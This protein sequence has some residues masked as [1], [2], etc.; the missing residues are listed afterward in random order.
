ME[1]RP[2]R[3][4]HHRHR[5]DRA[6]T[7]RR[8]S[9]PVRLDRVHVRGGDDL[10]G[11]VPARPHQAAL[12]AGR[13]VAAARARDRRRCPPTPHRVAEPRPG[14]PV[15]LHQ[16]AAHVRVA[17]PGRRVRV[18]GERRP[19]GAAA[20]LVLG[21]VGP[22]AG[23]VGLLRLPG[24]DPVLD[25]HLPRARAGAVHAVGGADHLVVAPAVPVE[26]VRLPPAGLLQGPQVGRHLAP[27]QV[28]PAPHQCLVQIGPDTSS[29]PH[30]RTSW[31]TC[32]S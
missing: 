1:P 17:D 20:G 30:P 27:A 8:R 31:S 21:P 22:D 24:D 15:H 3:V 11:L 4:R 10:G 19:P 12:A 2:G 13:L 23:V 25:V 7:R 16:H 32:H 26:A 29:L 9:G 5:R 18:P 6:R 14:L 28:P